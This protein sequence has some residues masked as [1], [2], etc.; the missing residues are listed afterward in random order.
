MNKFEDNMKELEEIVNSL[1]SGKASLDECVTLFEKGV[2]LTDECVK[3]LDNAEQK[4]KILVEK[5][6]GDV[7]EEDFDENTAQ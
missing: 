2:K 5:T 6:N 7:E 3:M 1:E 4:I